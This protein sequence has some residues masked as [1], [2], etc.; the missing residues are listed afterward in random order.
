[1]PRCCIEASTAR[2]NALPTPRRERPLDTAIKVTSANLAEICSIKL[3]A[4]ITRSPCHITAV[5]PASLIEPKKSSVRVVACLDGLP[6]R[7]LP[8]LPAL[9]RPL[10][11]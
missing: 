6:R 3:Q 2:S 7:P 5:A 1:M 4:A 10:L 9:E 8:F 11:S